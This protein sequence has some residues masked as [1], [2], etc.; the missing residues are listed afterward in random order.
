M[1]EAKESRDLGKLFRL[2]ALVLAVILV[3]HLAS[4][5]INVLAR[6]KE[7][8][9]QQPAD[10]TQTVT[11]ADYML[12]AE[13]AIAAM[14]YAAAMEHLETAKSLAD[15]QTE[16]S[17]LADILVKIVSI[18]IL[19]EEYAA[20]ISSIE[21]YKAG[22]ENIQADALTAILE[23]LL[24]GCRMQT[25]E[26]EQ[27]LT[28]FQ[29]ALALG[30]DQAACLEQIILSGFELGEYQVVAQAGETLLAMETV[31]LMDPAMV[32]QELGISHVYQSNFEKALEYLDKTNELTQSPQ[33][34][35]YYRG[36]CLISLARPQ[37]A[38]E[39]FTASIEEETLLSY[40]YYNRGVCCLDLLEYAQA[41]ADM[42]KTI[43]LGD[44]PSLMEAAQDVL[45][46][47][48]EAGL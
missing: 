14:E 18:Q 37:E 43:A 35:G 32:Y 33:S 20:A 27:A 23:F 30:Y 29:S 2:G 47:L 24:G 15:P 36:I 13:E 48:D 31:S 41:R 44:D 19:Q 4:P 21:S 46:Q 25:L 5:G 12:L 38:K 16:A 42:E 28:A 8:P 39:A 11:A 7:E 17:V 1:N 6:R 10:Q 45:A 9:A 40:C 26:Y 3:F 34:N 22:K